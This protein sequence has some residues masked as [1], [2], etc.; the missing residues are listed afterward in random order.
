[1]QQSKSKTFILFTDIDGTLLNQDR[2]VSQKNMQAL[3]SAKNTIRVAISG[4]NLTSARRVLPPD[5]PIDYLVFSNGAG[6]INWHSGQ[7]IYSQNL[8]AHITRQAAKILINEGITFTVHRPIPDTHYYFY[9]IG[10]YIPPDLQ[11]RNDYYKQYIAELENLS[12]ISESTCIICMLT[13]EEQMFDDLV[14]MLKSL[15]GEISITR[16]TSPFTHQ[17]IWLEIYD[18]RVNK[19]KT[20]Q[21]LCKMLGIEH[22]NTIGIGNDYNDLSLL[23]F[24]AFPFVVDN[25]PHDLKNRFNSTADHNNHAIAEV[26]K[27]INNNLNK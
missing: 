18:H 20:A 4:R 10:N 22:R 23:E 3:E 5:L 21:W 11:M 8:N 26:I 16:T 2:N 25:A 17:Q 6:I 27:F 13:A 19:G 7:L 24:V 1:M 14:D 15:Q 12:Q 9:H